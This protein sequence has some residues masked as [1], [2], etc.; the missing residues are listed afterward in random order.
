MA[1]EVTSDPS[2]SAPVEIARRIVIKAS[3]PSSTVG[4]TVRIDPVAESVLSLSVD[5]LPSW[6]EHEYG[7]WARQTAS[8]GDAPALGRAFLLYTHLNTLRARVWCDCCRRFAHLLQHLGPIASGSRKKE[9]DGGETELSERDEPGGPDPKLLVHY[10]R[11]ALTFARDGVS[12]RVDWKIG[13]DWAGEPESRLAVSSAV[14][15]S[16]READERGSLGK[17]GRVFDQLAQERGVLAAV[18]IVV[19]V[20]FEEE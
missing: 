8:T 16:W 17:L 19:T 15:R 9:G 14:P 1:E 10:G 3:D 13:F 4:L 5:A 18:D 7:S 11:E 12:V 6:A 2:P 20:V